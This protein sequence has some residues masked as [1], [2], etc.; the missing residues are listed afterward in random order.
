MLYISC[1]IYDYCE[2]ELAHILL[3]LYRPVEGKDAKC[4]Y[5]I[6]ACTV[7]MLQECLMSD[8]QRKFSMEKLQKG[9]C[10]QGGQRKRYKDTHKAWLKDFIIQTESW[11][12][13]AQGRTKWRCLINK[14]AAQFVA[15]KICEAER[16]HKE[17]KA[18]ANGLSCHQ[19]RHSPSSHALFATDSLELKLV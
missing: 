19:T 11:E 15:K 2:S 12:Q 7:K 1:I 10:S 8:C 18:R 4:T 6:E 5:F 17:W 16:K 3:L 9:M 13:A 14:G